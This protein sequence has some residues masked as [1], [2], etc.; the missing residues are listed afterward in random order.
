MKN[1]FLPAIAACLFLA[2]SAQAEVRFVAKIYESEDKKNLL[3][4]YKS[5]LD[6]SSGHPVV[7]NTYTTPAGEVVAIE[8]AEF[9]DD[10]M[11]NIKRYAMDQKQLK[12][13]GELV[14][15]GDKGKFDFDRDGKKKND[16]EKVGDDLIVGP[17]VVSHLQS[18][19]DKILKGE[20]IKRRFA[21]LD[22]IET[23]GFQFSKERD[24]EV[25]GQ[26]A[27]VVKMKPTSF[28]I[29]AIVDPLMFYMK[30]DGS[31]LLRIDGRV[32]V[33]K[34]VGGKWKDLDAVTFI[35]HKAGNSK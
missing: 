10:K 16:V 8:T 32:Q 26:K 33:K 11:N 19:W 31:D 14:V 22:R 23:V 21:V 25:D 29:A 27:V 30:A 2:Q 6:K 3:Y 34:N 13:K 1:L 20:T 35:D 12:T 9:S 4:E 28:V 24:A 5:E 7:T 15:E 17:S 18:N